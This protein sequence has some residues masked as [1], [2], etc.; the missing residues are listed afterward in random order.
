MTRGIAASTLLFGLF[1]FCV[2][3]SARTSHGVTGHHATDISSDRRHRHKARHR[4]HRRHHAIRHRHRHRVAVAAPRQSLAGF[5]SPL[6]AKAHELERS[7][8]SHIISAFRP[9]ARIAGSGRVSNHALRKA[10][11]MAGNPGCMYAHMKGWPG[12]Y[13]VD[14]GRVRHIHISYNRQRE[15][16]L[17]FAH[18]VGSRRLA[19]MYRHHRYGG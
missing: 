14:Y 15:W 18:Y 13:S 16:G 11:D 5:P 7:C 17:K 4:H 1:V 3:A 6:V 8:G 19:R 10:I 2:P 9:H 12:G